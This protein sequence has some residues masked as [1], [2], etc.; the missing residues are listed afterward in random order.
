MLFA[1]LLRL[2]T[3][4]IDAF[5]YP[6]QLVLDPE[7][8]DISVI[9]SEM[10]TAIQRAFASST[11]LVELLLLAPTISLTARRFRDAGWKPW[12]SW[13]S[14]SGIYG[15]LAVSLVVASQML[16]ALTVAGADSVV[17]A[18]ILGGFFVLLVALLVQFSSF[19]VI[20]VGAL[21]PSRSVATD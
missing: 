5:I 7:T 10:A 4:T 6:D 19:I 14:Y 15:S 11:F 9:A 8:T 17:D 2:V 1:V 13:A 16:S 3:T 20:L 21:R 18:T 12:L